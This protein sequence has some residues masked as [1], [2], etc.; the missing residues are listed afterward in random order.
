MGLRKWAVG[1]AV[2][3]GGAGLAWLA[4]D[5]PRAMGGKPRGERAARVQAS[6]QF[7]DGKFRNSIPTLSVPSNGA[8]V[9]HDALFGGQ[10]RR[11][12]GAVPVVWGPTEPATEGL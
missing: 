2:L 10:V 4:R 3:L 5:V 8:K 1:S 12:R 11:P 6:P 9:L 7:R